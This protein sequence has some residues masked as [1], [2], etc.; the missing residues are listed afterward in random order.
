MYAV[1]MEAHE[2]SVWKLPSRRAIKAVKHQNALAS[3]LMMYR[4]GDARSDMPCSKVTLVVVTFMGS[5]EFKREMQ[6]Y[7]YVLRRLF[8][9]VQLSCWMQCM[10]VRNEEGTL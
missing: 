4:I 6:R 1:G 7:N 9:V 5:D 3:S 10:M 2:L 8:A